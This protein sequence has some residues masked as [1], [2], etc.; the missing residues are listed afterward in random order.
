M[1]AI[2][3]PQPGGRAAHGP[4]EDPDA[5]LAQRRHPGR[6]GVGRQRADRVDDLGRQSPVGAEPERGRGAAVVEPQ[7]GAV[8]AEER[9][10]LVDD[11]VEEAGDIAPTADLGRDPAEG[12]GPR[13]PRVERAAGSAGPG[14]GARAGGSSVARR[15]LASAMCGWTTFMVIEDR[16]RPSVAG[17]CE[18]GT[19]RYR[20]GRWP[21]GT[22]AARRLLASGRALAAAPRPIR[23]RDRPSRGPPPRRRPSGPR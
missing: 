22:I 16:A 19:V 2:D 17:R 18:N 6:R 12:I 11:V 15:S 8:D 21:S 3:R 14:R 4:I 20:P 1:L 23:A 10:G 9:E 13:G 7:P 5:P